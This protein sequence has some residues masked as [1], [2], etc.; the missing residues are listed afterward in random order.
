MADKQRHKH[1]SAW[2]VEAAVDS[3][4]AIEQ[5]D[6]VWQDTNDAKPASDVADG[7]TLAL[8]Q[9]ALHDDFLGVSNERSLVGETDTININTDGVHEFICA[10][11]TFE[12][13]ALVGPAQGAATLVVNQTVIAVATPNL[14]IG[15]VVKRYASNTTKVLVRILSTTLRGGPQA[16]A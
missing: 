12:L 5:G 4:T 9:E 15:R 7:G 10:A 3:A 1:G 16:A 14:A 6:M 13:G 8:T 2:P 11:A